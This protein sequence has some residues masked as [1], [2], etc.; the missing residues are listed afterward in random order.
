MA[1][2][3][4]PGGTTPRTPRAA[5]TSLISDQLR[6]GPQYLPGGDDPPDPPSRPNFADLRSASPWPAVFTWGERP[7]G[8]PRAALTSLISDQ[9]RHGP[10]YLPGG[11]DPP[12]PPSRPNFADLRSA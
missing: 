12:D 10:Q 4:Y 2:S 8:P 1:R 3:I 7:P 9:L 5:L 11:N 6:H